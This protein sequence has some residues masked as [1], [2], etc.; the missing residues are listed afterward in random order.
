MRRAA[1]SFNPGGS[2]AFT[3]AKPRAPRASHPH[4][5]R[6]AAAKRAPAASQQ[7]LRASR[8]AAGPADV[9]R[10]FLPPGRAAGG[11]GKGGLRFS[12]ASR[13]HPGWSAHQGV[14]CGR[15][16]RSGQARERRSR[17]S[18]QASAPGSPRTPAGFSSGEARSSRRRGLRSAALQA[19]A[20][21]AHRAPPPV[22]RG[23][24]GYVHAAGRLGAPAAR[25]RYSGAAVGVRRRAGRPAA[26]R[27]SRARHS[28]VRPPSG[29][30]TGACKGPRR[31]PSA[32]AHR[33]ACRGRRAG[34]AVRRRGWGSARGSA[35]PDRGQVMAH[36]DGGVEARV[37]RRGGSCGCTCSNWAAQGK[38]VRLA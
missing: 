27:R 15:A 8:R 35:A 6:A 28:G 30:P 13:L 17:S 20:I 14:A 5:Y 37:E 4:R 33:G 34:R 19:A 32:R 3:R 10:E 36:D 21:A 25:A 29:R 26:G 31:T 7:R 2:V 23:S 16:D 12:S 1:V 9:V 24:A 22:A 11:G 18:N 38:C